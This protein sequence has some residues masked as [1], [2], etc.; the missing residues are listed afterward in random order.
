MSFILTKEFEDLDEIIARHIQPMAATVRDIMAYKYYKDSDG[1]KRDILDKL[2][3]EEKKKA[4]FK[5]LPFLFLYYNLIIL[6]L[7]TASY[8][9]MPFY[10]DQTHERWS[11]ITFFHKSLPCAVLEISLHDNCKIYQSLF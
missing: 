11:S 9:F 4:P 2:L 3:T 6:P 10:P 8:L 5:Y 1:G 7:K